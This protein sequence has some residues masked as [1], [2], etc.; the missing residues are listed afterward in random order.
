VGGFSGKVALVTGGAS[1][2]G[3]AVCTMFAREGARVLVS[4]VDETAGQETVRLIEQA[5]GE[6]IFGR[7]DVSR[8]EDCQALVQLA[9]DRFGRLDTACNNA[10]IGGEANPTADLSIEGWQRVIDINLSGV[11]YCLKYQ[12]PA[13]MQSGGGSITIMGSILGRVGFAGSPAYVA[14]KHG[15]VGLAKNAA[16]EYSAKGVRVNLVG[17]GFIRTP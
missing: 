11:F 1:G 15:L 7:A 2:I 3:R 12:I 13:I 16:L 8:P 10:G 9:L 6:A 4:D 14:A 5:G 17:P